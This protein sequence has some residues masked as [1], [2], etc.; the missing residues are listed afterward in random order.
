MMKL[1]HSYDHIIVG[2]GARALLQGLNLLAQKKSVA[3]LVCDSAPSLADYLPCPQT[4]VLETLATYWPQLQIMQ[5][6][7][8][9]FPG[10]LILGRMTLTL[11]QDSDANLREWKRKIGD[12]RRPEIWQQV[13]PLLAPLAYG[14]DLIPEFFLMPW[15]VLQKKF[16]VQEMVSKFTSHGGAIRDANVQEVIFDG[17]KASAV[18]IDR[19]EGVVKCESLHFWGPSY[20]GSQLVPSQFP[21]LYRTLTCQWREP[22]HGPIQNAFIFKS[23]NIQD[24]FPFA[25]TLLLGSQDHMAWLA[26]NAE[27]E[28]YP[29]DLQTMGD[30]VAHQMFDENLAVPNRGQKWSEGVIWPMPPSHQRGPLTHLKVGPIRPLGPRQTSIPV[31]I[32][33]NF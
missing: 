30:S 27:A 2:G 22:T 19:F 6:A 24:E 18:I 33:L 12:P 5:E 26:Y 21:G 29:V 3:W 23:Q 25:Y 7:V 17:N 16:I 1:S 28:F 20:P 10:T 11:G 4:E 8:V 13:E 9:P 15:V 32:E 14:R 31:N